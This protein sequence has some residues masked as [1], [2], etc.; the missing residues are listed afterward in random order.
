MKVCSWK[1][2][3]LIQWTHHQHSISASA[4]HLCEVL[5][6]GLRYPVQGVMASVRP[7]QSLELLHVHQE[8]P[9]VAMLQVEVACR[10]KK[11]MQRHSALL[12]AM[13]YC[14]CGGVPAA[15]ALLKSLESWQEGVL[16]ISS[17]YRALLS[18]IPCGTGLQQS[19]RL[20]L[21][22]GWVSKEIGQAHFATNVSGKYLCRTV[23][24]SVDVICGPGAQSSC[25]TLT[26]HTSPCPGHKRIFATQCLID[27]PYI[28][29]GQYLSSERSR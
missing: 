4:A 14:D 23:P 25:N 19:G 17:F 11:I 9:E 12:I 1:T 10:T 20:L 18:V 8:V 5:R 13:I 6:A 21:L 29:R 2:V 27:Q 15:A 24:P 28:E 16:C 3:R 7:S 22:T 26:S